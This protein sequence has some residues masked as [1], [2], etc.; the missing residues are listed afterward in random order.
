MRAIPPPCGMV[1]LAL[2]I[3]STVSPAWGCLLFMG[4]L[5]GLTEKILVLLAKEGGGSELA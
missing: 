1:L 5:F 3:N 2:G 4:K